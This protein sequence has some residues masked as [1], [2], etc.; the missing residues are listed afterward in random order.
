MRTNAFGLTLLLLTSMACERSPGRCPAPTA[1]E[2]DGTL[3]CGGVT[4]SWA[5]YNESRPHQGLPI[6]VALSR[7]A[8]DAGY[9]D[10]FKRAG[11]WFNHRLQP[12]L[13]ER[14]FIVIPAIDT[15]EPGLEVDQ[16]EQGADLPGDV[17][18]DVGDPGGTKKGRTW[19]SWDLGTCG[20]GQTRMV[21]HPR[22]ANG[23]KFGIA[24][25]ELAHAAGLPHRA[26][27]DAVTCEKRVCPDESE[28]ELL[29]EELEDLEWTL[30]GNPPEL[31][32]DPD[33][34][35]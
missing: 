3:S 9:F 28:C 16:T 33:T 1:E 7:D 31:P 27:S 29:A 23:H 6:V 10:D 12:M 14:A 19:A 13:G 32:I 21:V 25:H 34:T 2:P 20:M 30:K 4:P 5:S 22:L 26:H 24:V 15:G 18:V 8:I 11:N 17:Y 35:L